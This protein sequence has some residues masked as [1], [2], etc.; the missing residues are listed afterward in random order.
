M[1][2]RQ[3]RTV[4]DAVPRRMNML[5]EASPI[6]VRRSLHD[7]MGGSV[8]DM[9]YELEMGVV[10]NGRIRRH[11][12]GVKMDLERG[13]PWFCGMWEPHGSEAL[14]T[15]TEALVLVIMPEV[16]IGARFSEMPQVDW[17][18]PF[19]GA[20]GK[21]P[22]PAPEAR[23]EIVH[24]AQSIIDLDR[25]R[26]TYWRT[27]LRL[28]LY[29]LLLDLCQDWRGPSGAAGASSHQ[30]GKIAHA[31]ERVFESR[32]LVTVEEAAQVCHMGRSRFAALF[33][34]LMG[35]TFSRFALRHRLKGAANQLVRTNDPLKAVSQDWGFTDA[36]HLHRCFLSHFGCSPTRYRRAMGEM[37]SED[38]QAAYSTS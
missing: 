4:D 20:P 25:E 9:H 10:L 35:V 36:S 30:F 15:P 29:D 5:S 28:A 23:E 17:L 1:G 16:L 32:E 13:Q 33:R 34:E 19:T 7:S 14:Q 2:K 24:K 6:H 18:A 8:F 12:R 31:I 38:R 21:R 11:Y 37:K 26:P 22:Q 27:R 3:R